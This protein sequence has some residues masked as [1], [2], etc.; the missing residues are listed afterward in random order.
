M[1]ENAESQMFCAFENGNESWPDLATRLL[2]FTDRQSTK[3]D[4][5]TENC[6]L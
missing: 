1:T 4:P 3:T 6:K 5:Y 2:R